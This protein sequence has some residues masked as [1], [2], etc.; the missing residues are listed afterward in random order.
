[1]E[2]FEKLGSFYLGRPYDLA[3]QKPQEGVLLYDAKDLL[4][5]GVCVG[6]TGSGKTGLC[7]ALLEEAAIDGIPAIVIDPKGD[8]ANLL[9][10][11][12]D[13]APQDFRPWV[14]E[15]EA[16]RKGLSPDDFAAAEAARWAEGLAAWGQDGERIRA[17][18]KTVDFALYTPGSSAATPVSVL[19][20][21]DPPA[22]AILADEELLQDE[23]SGVA[24]S[25]LGLVGLDADPM[26]SR[27]HILLSTILLDA[28]RK[29]A[30]ID[31]AG[32]IRSIQDPPVA[33]IG[34]MSLESFFPTKDRFD[35][36]LR[37]NQLLA[38]PSFSVWMEGAPLD[39]DAFLHAPDGR[40][41]V[42]ILSIAHLDDAQRMFFVSLLLN[43]VL[44]WTR[45]QS[46][47]SSLR[48]I[49]YMDE[50]MGYFPP[51]S[52]PP[53]KKPL[54]TLLKQAR[55]FG[56]GVM[57]TTQNPV[58]LDYKGLANTG[59]WFIGRLQ[60]ERDKGRL[61]DG[62]E[63]AAG[64]Q[65]A[66][67]DRPEMERI[68]AGLGARIFLMHNVHDDRPII[69]ESRWCL[70]YLRG[71]LTRTQLQQLAPPKGAAAPVAPPAAGTPAPAPTAFEPVPAPPAASAPALPAE[72]R[73]YHLPVRGARSDAS[74]LLYRPVLLGAAQIGYRA[75]QGE[76]QSQRE[77]LYQVPVTD[78][79]LPVDWEKAKA[80]EVEL[81]DLATTGESGARYADLPRSA[82]SAK[83]YP[84]WSR[85][86]EDWIYRTQQLDLLRSADGK[87]VSAPGESE[88]DFRI[89]L[90]QAT[91]EARDAELDALRTKYASR[92]AALE[93]K[94]R[95]ATQAVEREKEQAKAQQLQTAI[96]FGATLLGSFL[97]T[98]RIGV[99]SL[100]R[101]TT[102]A[103]GVGRSIKEAGDV[104]RVKETV[105]TYTAQRQQ[106]EEEFKAET[107]ELATRLDPMNQTLVPF[108][109]RPAK[110]DIA[111]RALVLLWCPV[112]RS[113]DG[114]EMP[115]WE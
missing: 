8:L 37:F 105:E 106:L 44:S 19:R 12:P 114:T 36:A 43:R 107:D 111:V 87:Q 102:A 32:L 47:T 1:M 95:K 4:T 83:N 57:L 91:R 5:H 13:L 113:A 84:V 68:L 108:V 14:D 52:T 29:G 58:D 55:A 31:L 93:E 110:K 100:G 69:F 27:E 23:V 21:F 77:A 76:V 3:A 63:G 49:L 9:L 45:R 79:L 103:R 101:A 61:L 54:L 65:G 16:R 98:K 56:L 67:F 30:G 34:V 96:S 53:S 18:K 112:R 11:F 72:I 39:V 25:L 6:M 88:R 73:Q 86:F 74:T 85:E 26:R 22:A 97:G 78:E 20:S 81:S 42:S 59:T 94:I 15:E 28:W 71:P 10:A 48:A 38:S 66:A 80:L 2:H 41:R 109:L 92:L 51:V 17:M 75:G 50:I 33:Q 24:G 115:A 46:G 82:A 35:L 62:L 64:A 60:T 7:M 104:G 40:P 70:S 89:R 90:Q 99:S